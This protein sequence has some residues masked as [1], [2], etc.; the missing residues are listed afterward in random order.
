MDRGK[1]VVEAVE[2]LLGTEVNLSI[3]VDSNVLFSTLSVCRMAS[4]RSIRGDFS[5]IRF[6]FATK[7]VSSMI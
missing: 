3:A 1:V 5:S 7:N 2:E 6:E 4:D